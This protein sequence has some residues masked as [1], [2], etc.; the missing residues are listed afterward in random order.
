MVAERPPPST[1]S[2]F[3]SARAGRLIWAETFTDLHL[4]A[5]I[6]LH[7]GV[8]TVSWMPQVLSSLGAAGGV[9]AV[10][11]Y[12]IGRRQNRTSLQVA[13]VQANT[14]ADLAMTQ[15]VIEH[16]KFR[17]QKLEEAYGHLML[18]LHDMES[19][20]NDLWDHLCN[21]GAEHQEAATKLLDDWPWEMLRP[22][23]DAARMRYFWSA[24][25]QDLIGNLNE[26][27]SGLLNG[28]WA[29]NIHR[30]ATGEEKEKFR[31]GQ[32]EFWEH[33]T[34]ILKTMTDVRHAIRKELLDSID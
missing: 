15:R 24:K 7:N 23:R 32:T 4:C 33:R 12:L 1:P 20:I 17:R 25:V 8:V 27:S 29:A 30:E 18:W 16:D 14:Q 11:S 34:K 5:T 22:P 31:R 9:S 6:E 21:P 3:L 26:L 10:T 19:S 13:H 28:G 2:I